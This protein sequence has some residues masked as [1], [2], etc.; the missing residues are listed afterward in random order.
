M[1]EV[2]RLE[3]RYFSPDGGSVTVLGVDSLIVLPAQHMAVVGPSGSGKSTLL[4]MIGG[5]VEP[6]SGSMRWD[7]DPWPGK[8]GELG[9]RERARRVG[10]VFQELNLLPGLSL[11]DNLGTAA[12][13]LG[14]RHADQAVR[15]ALNRVGLSDRRGHKPG[16]LSRGERQ[17]AAI[18]RAMMYPHDLILADEPTA[19]LDEANAVLV[20]NLLI[21]MAS[22]NGSALLVATHDPRVMEKLPYRYDL[23]EHRIGA[24]AHD[25]AERNGRTP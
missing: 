10:F 11:L 9:A 4:S 19:S 2:E 1:I 14:V 21:D 5:V 13:F 12:W 23:L 24:G 25:G 22:D 18:A 6:S 16:Q 17:R 20:M 15:E 3:K 7:G 8:P